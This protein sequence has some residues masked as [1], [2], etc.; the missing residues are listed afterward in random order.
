[1]TNKDR[2][3]A[4]FNKIKDMFKNKF[5][6]LWGGLFAL[7]IL[8][9]ALN[10]I[11]STAH[12]PSLQDVLSQHGNPQSG[13]LLVAGLLA[14]SLL[15]VSLA[16]GYEL[17]TRRQAIAEML[18]P[19]DCVCTEEITENKEIEVLRKGIK[20]LRETIEQLDS[21]KEALQLEN[22]CLQDEFG[23]QQTQLNDL[24]KIE[25]MLRQSNIALGKECERMKAHNEELVLKIN[26]F[27]F[28]GR[29]KQVNNKTTTAKRL[30]STKKNKAKKSKQ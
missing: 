13:S 1:M 24:A 23:Y 26:S 7:A 19:D 16:K 21:G 27:Q 6:R 28:K 29:K 12:T 11:F 15:G 17:V 25:Q 22:S 20:E 14:L 18:M 30:L 9:L 4:T 2:V 3:V 10:F 8:L 5:F